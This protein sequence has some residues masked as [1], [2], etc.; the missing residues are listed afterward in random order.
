ML[1]KQII[2]SLIYISPFY[3]VLTSLER[4]ILFAIGVSIGLLLLVADQNLFYSYYN[5]Q[6]DLEDIYLVTRSAA[7]LLTLIPLSLFVITSTM[8]MLGIGVVMSLILNLLVEMSVYRRWPQAF[9]KRFLSE[10]EVKPEFG[11]VNQILLFTIAFFVILNVLL[12][13]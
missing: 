2:I 10:V 1:Q 4:L 13:F 3:F 6:Q 8:S 5:E 9:K 7:F 11:V 12:I